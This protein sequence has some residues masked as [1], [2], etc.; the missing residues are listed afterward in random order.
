MAVSADLVLAGAHEDAVG[1]VDVDLLL[2]LQENGRSALRREIRVLLRLETLE[3]AILAAQ[4]MQLFLAIRFL[5][6]FNLKILYV[7][8]SMKVYSQLRGSI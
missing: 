3:G 8:I 1:A 4:K 5:Q 7:H 2:L 6:Q